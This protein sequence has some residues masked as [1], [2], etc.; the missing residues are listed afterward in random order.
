MTDKAR[1]AE[2]R[3]QR[4]EFD[5]FAANYSGGMDNPVKAL[6]G[7]SSDD[8]L[9]VKLDWLLRRSPA[10]VKAQAGYEVLD[11]GCGTASMLRLIADRGIRATL[12]GSDVSQAMLDEGTARWPV[13]LGRVPN[14]KLQ[15]SAA[16]PFADAQFDLIIVSAVLH[17]VDLADRN[18]VYAELLRLLKPNGELVVFEHNPWNPV[19]RYV[20]TRSPIDENAI[21]LPPPEVRSGLKRAGFVRVDTRFLMFLPPRLSFSSPVDELLGFLPLGAQYAVHAY[22]Q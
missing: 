20:V 21:L 4:A 7:K 22:R 16:T 9:Q 1:A 8:F 3:S 18:A 19:T 5:A 17:H 12:S 10:F 15:D 13:R 14:L 11:Y 2:P 6:L